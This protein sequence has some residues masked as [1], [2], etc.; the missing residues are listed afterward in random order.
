MCSIRIKTKN[1]GLKSTKMLK[2]RILNDIF[3]IKSAEIIPPS[4]S[5]RNDSAY[6]FYSL[7]IVCQDEIKD[8][9]I[10]KYDLKR[11]NVTVD[12]SIYEK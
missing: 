5:Y 10:N 1:G 12:Y 4:P 11:V 6:K 9:L 8:K 2:K 3:E 7:Y